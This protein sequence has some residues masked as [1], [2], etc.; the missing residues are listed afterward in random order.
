MEK[1]LESRL[2][3]LRLTE[4]SSTWDEILAQAKIKNP[5]YTMFL[6]QIIEQE[7]TAKQNRA[8]EQ[9]LRRAKIEDNYLLETYPF[10]RQ[11]N[12]SKNKIMEIFDSKAYIEK[13]QNMILIGPTGVG[14]TGLA[15][16]LLI[17]AVKAGLTGRFITFPDL[18][19]ELHR[20]EADHSEKKI[21]G[22][23]LGYECLVIDELG[24]IEIDQNQAGMFFT[25]MKRRHKK[26]TTI[27]TTQL[28]FK[29]W[30]G[31]LKN[32]HLTSALIDRLMENFQL[33]NMSKCQS[34]RQS[35]PKPK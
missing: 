31:F 4:L 7:C 15:T 13:K 14:K 28:G 20:S 10:E 23:F 24:Y 8:R 17:H 26:S 3:Y 25:L 34:L 5:S 32:P 30:T 9:R 35:S 33:I 12:L 29:E 22:K 6:K 21:L 18:L 1:D 2:R 27:I 16:A 11:P 19:N